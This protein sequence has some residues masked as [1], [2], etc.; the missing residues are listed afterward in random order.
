LKV[1]GKEI[2]DECVNMGENVFGS[3]PVREGLV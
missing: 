3:A 1:W 2:A